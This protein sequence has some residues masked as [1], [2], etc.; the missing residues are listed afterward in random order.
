MRR[1]VAVDALS[2][3]GCSLDVFEQ[4]FEQGDRRGELMVRRYDEVIEVRETPTSGPSLFLWRGR[5]Y[6]V[7]SVLGHWRERRAWWLEGATARLLGLDPEGPPDFDSGPEA[8]MA[9]VLER[10]IWRVE[11]GAGRSDT[12]GVYDLGRDVIDDAEDL[13]RD[14]AEVPTRAPED[15]L[16]DVRTHWRLLQVAD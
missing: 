8:A 13:G 4:M 16:G 3:P 7:R 2:G 12:V 15:E 14:P 11:A 5:V 10:E 9:D 1:R 6:S